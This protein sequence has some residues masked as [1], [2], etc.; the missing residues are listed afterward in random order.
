MARAYSQ[1]L[2]DRV[3]DA[4]LAGRLRGRRQRVLGLVMR[5]RS[6][7]CAGRAKGGERTARKQGQDHGDPGPDDRVNYWRGFSLN[8]ACVPRG[9]PCGRFS[10]A[11]A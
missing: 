8:A 4:A 5:R 9:R 11:A 10:T 1:D 3:I 2:R 6:S 7:G